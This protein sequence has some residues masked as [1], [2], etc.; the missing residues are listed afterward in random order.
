MVSNSDFGVNGHA[1][2]RHRYFSPKLCLWKIFTFLK[3]IP[4]T[5]IVFLFCCCYGAVSLLITVPSSSGINHMHSA[6]QSGSLVGQGPL[7]V[8]TM[9][10]QCLVPYWKFVDMLALLRTNKAHF[11]SIAF[12]LNRQ[13]SLASFG[14]NHYKGGLFLVV[15]TIW[16]EK[17]FAFNSAVIITCL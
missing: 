4:F 16:E 17:S 11:W 13:T 7:L 10:S 12:T 9:T 8:N 2:G 1:C 15:R 5:A 3:K 6:R 14:R